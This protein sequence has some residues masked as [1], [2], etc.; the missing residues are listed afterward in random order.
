MHVLAFVLRRVGWQAA[1]EDITADVFAVAWRRWDDVPE[2]SRPWLFGVA[3]KLIANHRR[4]EQR[5]TRLGVKASAEARTD[6]SR[7]VGDVV[8]GSGLGSWTRLI[9]STLINRRSFACR[10]GKASTRQRR[11]SS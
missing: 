11:R 4:G 9:S 10:R 5:R 7:D 6:H 2:V 8:G 1:A 3:L